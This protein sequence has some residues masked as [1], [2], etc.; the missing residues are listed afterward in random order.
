MDQQSS[1]NTY[2]EV[3]KTNSLCPNSSMPFDHYL[4]NCKLS[5]HGSN[6]RFSSVNYG[7]EQQSPF[8]YFVSTNRKFSDHTQAIFAEFLCSVHDH[9]GKLLDLEKEKKGYRQKQPLY[10]R[11]DK[12]N[13]D[14]FCLQYAGSQNVD[15]LTE[16]F[17]LLDGGELSTDFKTAVKQVLRGDENKPTLDKTIS[18][19]EKECDLVKFDSLIYNAFRVKYLEL[20][21]ATRSTVRNYLLNW[22]LGDNVKNTLIT[23][24]IQE[25]NIDVFCICE[26]NGSFPSSCTN[27]FKNDYYVYTENQN[28]IV[29]KKTLATYTKV[30]SNSDDVNLVNVHGQ[31]LYVLMN[32]VLDT[33]KNLLV[34]SSHLSDKDDK[35]GELAQLLTA[36]VNYEGDYVCTVD[37]NQ[38]VKSD[39][40]VVFPDEE[41]DVNTVDKMRTFTQ[42]QFGKAEFHDCGQ[43][44]HIIV[45]KNKDRKVQVT[46]F[47][48]VRTMKF[49]D[50]GES[51]CSC[52]IM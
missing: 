29:V 27:E 20:N 6:I 39:N 45:R 12:N 11:S 14:R 30:V 21:P 49:D 40:H 44:D 48:V 16:L 10:L 28:T 23:N 42:T 2:L 46:R 18:V 24:W 19:W 43:K 1:T 47:E 26:C 17:R 32:N 4:L 31:T 9:L 7:G 38:R 25:K 33:G 8:E 51:C 36:L 3:V 35:V 37:A 15:Y 52:R 34:V 13:K 5:F 50:D 41:N 22:N